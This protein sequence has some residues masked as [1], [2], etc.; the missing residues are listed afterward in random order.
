MGWLSL[1]PAVSK[2]A[3]E[4]LKALYGTDQPVK[5]VQSEAHGEA[6]SDDEYATALRLQLSAKHRANNRN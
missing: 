3:V 4:I 2:S 5:A 1:L 6:L